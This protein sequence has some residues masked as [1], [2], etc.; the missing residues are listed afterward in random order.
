MEVLKCNNCDAVLDVDFDNMIAFCPYCGN[1][2]MFD[3][4]EVRQ[5]LE[6]RIKEE[7]ETARV[8]IKEEETTAR[9]RIKAEEAAKR[10]QL[11]LDAEKQKAQ[12]KL[13][14]KKRREEERE[15]ALHMVIRLY[16]I[17]LGFF[18]LI[19]LSKIFH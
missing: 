1:K 5:I 4:A 8:K 19:V 6:T 18:A 17:I 13:D 12:I 15:K 3:I 11:Q 2:L 10:T 16:L 7:Q 14:K 9:K